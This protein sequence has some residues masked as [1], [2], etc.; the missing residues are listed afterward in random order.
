MKDHVQLG[1]TRGKDDP[2]VVES[3]PPSPPQPPLQDKLWRFYHHQ[4]VGVPLMA[5]IVVAA[6]MGVFGLTE[7][8]LVAAGSAVTLEVDAVERFRYRMPGRFDVTVTNSTQQAIDDVTLRIESGYLSGFAEISFSPSV[9]IID[10]QWW[11]FELGDLNPGETR[12]ISGEFRSEEVGSFI[13]D[14]EVASGGSRL[15][16]ITVE[17]LSYP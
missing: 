14:V 9:K 13:G 16:Q 11:T 3:E 15:A 10:Q 12:V 17:T 8:R 1:G 5:A 6:L 7:Q 2:R 4:L